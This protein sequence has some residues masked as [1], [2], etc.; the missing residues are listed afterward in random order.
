[1][2]IKVITFNTRHGETEEGIIDAI[3]QASEIK[4]YNPD[5]ILL[6]EV[7]MYTDR[8]NGFDE[9]QIFKNVVGLKY[10]VFGG[11]INFQNGGY[12]NA[13]LS[14]YPILKSE[15]YISPKYTKENRG[16]LYV[17]LSVYN[18][19]I[20][21]YNTHFP[22]KESERKLFAKQ[23]NRIVEN[24]KSENAIIGGDFN[25]GLILK[26]NHVYEVIKKEEYEELKEV[27]KFFKEANFNE[28]TYPVENPEGQFDK[29]MYSG[30]IEL[31]SVK[32]L[33]DK[34]SDHYP[35]IAEFEVPVT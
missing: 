28:D 3:K 5:V 8:I 6:Q 12:G 32:R 20:D 23:I 14:K 35:V 7:D 18:K 4:K 27:K 2:K 22:I 16:L 15:N 21:I 31:I 34:I 25:P 11:N 29:I 17:E 30:N 10:S 26:K 24:K 1:M 19:K 9:L 33:N 13:I